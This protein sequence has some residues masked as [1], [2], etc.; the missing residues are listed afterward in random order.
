MCAERWGHSAPELCTCNH[1]QGEFDS[2]IKV[3]H[4][5]ISDIDGRRM[6]KLPTRRVGSVTGCKRVGGKLDPCTTQHLREDARCSW[7]KQT[8]SAEAP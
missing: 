3:L 6:T 1:A 5:N 2:E 7:Q 8:D 4:A